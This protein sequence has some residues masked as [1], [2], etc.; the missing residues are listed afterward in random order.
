MAF[1]PVGAIAAAKEIHAMA[2]DAM[3]K[4]DKLLD[5]ADNVVHAVQV[6]VDS[7]VHGI[8]DRFSKCV[9]HLEITAPKAHAVNPEPVE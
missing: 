1:D 8:L 2:D 9:I 4:A 7:L 6:R 5:K 3:A